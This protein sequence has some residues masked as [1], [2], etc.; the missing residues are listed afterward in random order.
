MLD[1]LTGVLRRW[2]VGILELLLFFPVVLA[3]AVLIGPPSPLWLWLA[4]LPVMYL[5][6][7][8]LY[9][10]L[11]VRIYLY[12]V[13]AAVPAGGLW[14]YFAFGWNLSG[15]FL[16]PLCIAAWFRG[17][18]CARI[19][20]NRPYPEQHY[21]IGL[22]LYFLGYF[23]FRFNLLLQPYL[24]LF[25]WAGIVTI[26]SCFYVINHRHLQNISLSRQQKPSLTS[27]M[28]RHNRIY[29]TAVAALVFLVAGF[30]QVEAF[31][32]WLWRQFVRG[33]Q[34][35]VSLLP[36]PGREEPGPEPQREMQPPAGLEQGEPSP[37]WKIMELIFTYV[38]LGVIVIIIVALS[39]FAIYKISKS[40]AK[41]IRRL[42][43]WLSERKQDPVYSEGYRDEKESL[44]TLGHWGADYR[45]RFRQWLIGLFARE[46]RWE[47]LDGNREKIRYLYRHWLLH[48]IRK[49]Y[50]FKP[51]YTP[52][53]TESD[54]R[55]WGKNGDFPSSELVSLYQ[56]TRYGN[57]EPDDSAVDEL[58]RK[59]Q[60]L[61]K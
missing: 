37:F 49:G 5:A 26:V 31:F 21:W 28:V 52:G 43:Q 35:L 3:A 54:I 51:W 20:W 40:A 50:R 44:M 32:H 11:K 6:A 10:I 45:D 25:T 46:P 41:A 33:I 57:H 23:F 12:H 53:E 22:T 30:K 27:A 7:I 17:V 56:Q 60:N 9:H 36:S 15:I 29:I 24:A 18:Y 2:M 19:G 47:E 42:L 59:L 34:F 61:R 48:S 16:F 14:A 1:R 58:Y 38:T 8:V 13:L 4:A 39:A 55:Q